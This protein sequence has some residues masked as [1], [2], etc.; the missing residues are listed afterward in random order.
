M[1]LKRSG[2]FIDLTRIHSQC[3]RMLVVSIF[4][5]LIALKTA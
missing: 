5:F 1:T 4:S 2:N 3:V